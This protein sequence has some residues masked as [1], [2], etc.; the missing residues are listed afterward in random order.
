MQ[1][2]HLHNPC[3]LPYKPSTTIPQD[4]YYTLP[5]IAKI[6]HNLA[7]QGDNTSKFFR[8]LIRLI[9]IQWALERCQQGVAQPD[10]AWSTSILQ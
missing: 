1:H 10:E 3:M 9:V 2:F 5:H 7:L 4:L 8:Y 6:S